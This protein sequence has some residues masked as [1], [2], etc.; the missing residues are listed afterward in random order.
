MHTIQTHYNYCIQ[1]RTS[2]QEFT[3]KIATPMLMHHT[4]WFNVTRKVVAKVK[5]LKVIKR[6]YEVVNEKALLT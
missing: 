4:A 6:V 1:L 5:Q 2:V 3:P